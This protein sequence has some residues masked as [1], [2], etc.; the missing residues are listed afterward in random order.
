MIEPF[1]MAR[2]YWRNLKTKSTFEIE[3][4]LSRASTKLSKDYWNEV[5]TFISIRKNGKKS[6]N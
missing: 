4:W 6:Q 1:E 3:I 2:I 5:L